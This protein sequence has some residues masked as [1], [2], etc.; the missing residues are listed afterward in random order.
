MFTYKKIT[1]IQSRRPPKQNINDKLQA[2]AN[3]LGLFNLRDKD[4]SCF[5]IFIELIKAAKTEQQLTSDELAY[6][7]GLSRGT[8]VH[9]LNK[10][11]ESGLIIVKKNRYFLRVNNLKQL[12]SE[13]ERDLDN[14]MRDLKA[15]A[16]ELD[17]Q[18]GL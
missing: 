1:I 16:G 4:N 18:L 15:L 10:L 11:I 17:D 7:L 6:K 8:I 5:R 13:V 3:S 2:L 9:H 14:T 12:I